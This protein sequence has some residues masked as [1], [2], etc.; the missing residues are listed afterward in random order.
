MIDNLKIP[1]PIPSSNDSYTSYLTASRPSAFENIRFTSSNFHLMTLCL[2]C[3]RKS[4]EEEVHF[5][6]VFAG[7]WC[8]LLRIFAWIVWLLRFLISM[9]GIVLFRGLR[10]GLFIL[11]VPQMIVTFRYSQHFLPKIITSINNYRKTFIMI[12]GSFSWIRVCSFKYNAFYFF[13][14]NLS[15]L[16]IRSVSSIVQSCLA[17]MTFKRIF[18]RISVFLSPLILRARVLYLSL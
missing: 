17:E 10:Y 8:G 7:C 12:C 6:F 3:S 5:S 2:D 13:K 16:F 11:L 18:M 14:A 1:Q 9:L 4:K 15:S